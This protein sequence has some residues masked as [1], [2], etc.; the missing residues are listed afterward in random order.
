LSW[1][2]IIGDSAVGATVAVGILRGGGRGDDIGAGGYGG[3]KNKRSAPAAL[4]PAHR[5]W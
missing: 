1:W 5:D 4:P 3:M 2:C